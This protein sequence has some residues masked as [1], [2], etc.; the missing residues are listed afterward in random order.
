M[1][2][3]FTRTAK[4]LSRKYIKYLEQ[5]FNTTKDEI[6]SW[7][8]DKWDEIYDAL[9]DIEIEELAG[10]TDDEEESDRCKAASDLVTLLGNA[11]AKEEGTYNEEEFDNGFK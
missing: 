3:I 2:D 11:I 9:C 7:D 8:E 5:E 6:A 4:K 10:L 1:S